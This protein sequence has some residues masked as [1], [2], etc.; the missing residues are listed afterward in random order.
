MPS[1]SETSIN[2][3]EILSQI[4]VAMGGHVAE[5]LIVGTDKITSGCGSDLAGATSYA[6]KAVRQFGM[7]GDEVGFAAMDKSK[8]S[9]EYNAACDKVIKKILDVSFSED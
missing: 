5:K 8:A 3:A 9:E 7:F 2:K 6:T 4:D 1:D